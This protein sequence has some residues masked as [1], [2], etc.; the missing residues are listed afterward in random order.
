MPADLVGRFMQRAADMASTVERIASR[1]AIPAAVARYLDGLV[2]PGTAHDAA[3]R[4]GVCWPDLADLD[5]EGTGLVIEA[6]P[7]T[8]DDRLGITGTFCAIAETG[9]LVLDGSRVV[10][11]ENVEAVPGPGATR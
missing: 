7:T 6:R 1:A 11:P 3:G 10:S 9:T 8:G 2:P 4:R 5:W